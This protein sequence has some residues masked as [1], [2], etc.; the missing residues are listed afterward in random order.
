MLTSLVSTSL[1]DLLVYLRNLKTPLALDSV[2][3]INILNRLKALSQG[4]SSMSKVSCVR[5]HRASVDEL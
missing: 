2:I 5:A 3:H 4:D 1:A